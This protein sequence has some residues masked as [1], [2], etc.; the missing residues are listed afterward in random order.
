MKKSI[1]LLVLLFLILNF[2][3]KKYTESENTSSIEKTQMTNDYYSRLSAETNV[4]IRRL[5][6]SM[7]LQ[8]YFEEVA[9]IS[10][11]I[12]QNMKTLTE[13]EI[14]RMD[15]LITLISQAAQNNDFALVDIYFNE[16]MMLLYGTTNPWFPEEEHYSQCELVKKLNGEAEIFVDFLNSNY[17]T[18]LMLDNEKQI[19]VIEAIVNI[20]IEKE[21]TKPT[22]AEQCAIT[23][24]GAIHDAEIQYALT[25]AGCLFFTGPAAW[26]CVGVGLGIYSVQHNR[27]NKNYKTCMNGI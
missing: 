24:K 2:S 13:E 1:T 6:S 8:K 4:D 19:S 11:E 21:P 20:T 27:A 3:C 23:Y 15:E 18:F 7:E 26:A 9:P 17:P 5:A 25:V 22:P 14:A 12:L 10:V 16:L